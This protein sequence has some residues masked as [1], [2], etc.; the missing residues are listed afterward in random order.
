MPWQK[1][2]VSLQ[3][4]TRCRR[5]FSQAHN[6]V[7]VAIRL[8]QNSAWEN[9]IQNMFKSHYMMTILSILTESSSMCFGQGPTNSSQPLFGCLE[10]AVLPDMQHGSLQRESSDRHQSSTI[11]G[12]ISAEDNLTMLDLTQKS[13]DCSF[14]ITLHESADVKDINATYDWSPHSDQQKWPTNSCE[15]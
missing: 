14:Y 1:T 7:E 8:I 13:D 9:R 2:S 3:L 4:Y 11:L 15:S 6:I 10:A 12:Q 5:Q